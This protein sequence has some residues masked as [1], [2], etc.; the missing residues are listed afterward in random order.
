MF[1]DVNAV[2]AFNQRAPAAHKTKSTKQKAPACRGFLYRGQWG[3]QS[4]LLI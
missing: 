2:H 4:G 3:S 1:V